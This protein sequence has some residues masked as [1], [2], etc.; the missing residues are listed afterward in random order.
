[1][2]INA[3][4]VTV[5]SAL[6]GS[7]AVQIGGLLVVGWDMLLGHAS[8]KKYQVEA[9][10]V[11]LAVGFAALRIIEGTQL[12][13]STDPEATEDA[14]Q[15][16][17]TAIVVG[18]VG[19]LLSVIDKTSNEEIPTLQT[20]EALFYA[21]VIGLIF[22]VPVFVSRRDRP[23]L[24]ALTLLTYRIGIA[25]VIAFVA[26]LLIQGLMELLGT[27][28]AGDRCLAPSDDGKQFRIG[29]T[30]FFISAPT[31]AGLIAPWALLTAY[32]WAV[33]STWMS[34]SRPARIFWSVAYAVLALVL[35]AYYAVVDYAF[36][37]REPGGWVG[38][39]GL[40]DTSLVLSFWALQIPALCAAVAA[41]LRQQP[42]GAKWLSRQDLLYTM[43]AF[44][45]GVTFACLVAFPLVPLHV[46]MTP[47][48]AL[49]FAAC[50][51]LTAAAA[52]EAV[53]IAGRSL[54]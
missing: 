43:V 5:L 34:T 15:T 35:S 25:A 14:Q 19:G 22:V 50:H 45:V 44:V 39:K 46:G 27:F 6:L 49:V 41:A 1:M 4:A 52:T 42:S 32:P 36:H 18:F 17:S 16:A 37:Y 10:I 54:A 28:C 48:K 21:V 40:S 7:H 24:H 31:T 11:F 33:G 26:G 12:L 53:R 2:G 51:G 47:A 20:A 9:G 29:S 30:S 23:G 13:K 38:T 3:I 8:S